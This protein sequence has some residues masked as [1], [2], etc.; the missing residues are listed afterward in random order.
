MGWGTFRP[1]EPKG[2]ERP[3]IQ[4][5]YIIC[6]VFSLYY[7]LILFIIYPHEKHVGLQIA[8]KEIIILA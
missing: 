5:P 7:S 6:Y 3:D 8:D 4:A 2:P 1:F